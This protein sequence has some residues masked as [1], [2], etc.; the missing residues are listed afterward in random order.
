M[1]KMQI[2]LTFFLVHLGLLIH[3]NIGLL[4]VLCIGEVVA[5]HDHTVIILHDLRERNTRLF[6]NVKLLV[7]YLVV[8]MRELKLLIHH[9]A[10]RVVHAHRVR[11]Q[12]DGGHARIIYEHTPGAQ[13]LLE[14]SN[15]ILFV[16]VL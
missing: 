6:A 5:R 7:A 1:I 10:W 9:N 15:V 11:I 2:K 12:I 8:I 14:Y 16:H 4:I 3:F 13:L